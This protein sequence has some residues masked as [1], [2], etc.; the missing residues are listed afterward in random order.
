MMHPWKRSLGRDCAGFTLVELL[1]V[2]AII[3]VLLALLLPALSLARENAWRAECAAHLHNNGAALTAY[4]VDHDGQLPVFFGPSDWLW[5]IPLGTRDA[6]VAAGMQRD[7]FYCPSGSMKNQDGL[8]NFIGNG[9]PYC[10]TGYFWLIPRL[11]GPG[12]PPQS[13]LNP[14]NLI[15]PKSFVASIRVTNPSNVEVV[16]DATVSDAN[17]LTANFAGVS[18]GDAASGIYFLNTNHLRLKDPDK[19]AGGNILFLDGHVAW[20]DIS[21]MHVWYVPQDAPGVNHWF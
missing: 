21:D 3:A 14:S 18:G 17:S 8:W 11:A 9:I 6:L 4:A 7:C 10:V 5:D 2:V 12:N 1:I 13:S 15:L 20:R 16:T 19:A